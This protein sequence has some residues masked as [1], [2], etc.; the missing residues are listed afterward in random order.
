M[1]EGFDRAVAR[2]VARLSNR[3]KAESPVTFPIDKDAAGQAGPNSRWADEM[4]LAM[5]S[6]SLHRP[7]PSLIYIGQ[8]GATSSRS[9]TVRLATLRSR[10]RGNHLNGNISSSTFR[11]TLSAILREP[12]NLAVAPS[13]RL[14]RESNQRVSAWMREHLHLLIFP[15]E[16]RDTLG[17]LE[18][19]VLTAVPGS[20][21][22]LGGRCALPR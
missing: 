5:L 21:R 18:E 8:A 1:D 11:L 3:S 7:L 20:A 22:A 4:G 16:A 13:G 15:W 2:A 10:I 12:L 19:A 17:V 9:R 6:Q 14:D